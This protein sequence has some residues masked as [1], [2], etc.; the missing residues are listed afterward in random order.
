[1]IKQYILPVLIAL[2]ALSISVSAA[3]YSVFGLSKLFSGV[4]AA[5]IIMASALEASK[6]VIASLLHRYWATINK[7]LKVYLSFALVVLMLIT[8]AGIYGMLSSG[9]QQTLNQSN[10]IEGEVAIV[11]GKKEYFEKRISRI[12]EQ[13]TSNNTRINS[14]VNLRKQQETRLDTLYQR[15]KYY[16]ARKTENVIKEANKDIKTLET[17]ITDFGLNINNLNDS[18]AKLDQKIIEI[19]MSNEAAAELG[20]LKY[21]SELLDKPMDVIVN[22]LILTLV[23]VFDPLAI[24]LV[25]AANMAFDKIKYVPS[26]KSKNWKLYGETFWNRLKKIKLPKFKKEKPIVDEDHAL[27]TVMNQMVEDLGEDEIKN[28]VEEVKEETKSD[29]P[30]PNADKYGVKVRKK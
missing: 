24:S 15:E 22:W 12:E 18:I 8:S 2:S 11:K 5:I 14:L 16:S 26:T 28:I 30:K 1:M 9:Y 17:Q 3:Y 27:D 23:V 4:G 20:P 13:I 21:V 10:S 7:L 6:L 19:E 29:K 25:I